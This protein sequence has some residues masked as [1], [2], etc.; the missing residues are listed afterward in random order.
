MSSSLISNDVI[1]A[2]VL[3]K[4]SGNT[5][6]FFTGVHIDAKKLLKRFAFS[7]KSETNLPLT[8]KGGIAGFFFYKVVYLK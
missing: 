8:N 2:L 5:L 1:L 3:Y 6:E 4:S 7:Q